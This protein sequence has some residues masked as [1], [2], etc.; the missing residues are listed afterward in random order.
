MK[1]EEKNQMTRQRIMESA[2]KEFSDHG[3]TG[4][5][6]NTI[7]KEEGISKGIIYHYFRTKDE[8][9]LACVEECFGKLTIYL[10]DHLDLENKNLEEQLK[11]YF[12][13]RLRFFHLHPLY[14]RIFCDAVIMP[15]EHLKDDIC[16]LKHDF[17]EFNKEIL[18]RLL[19]V[20]DIRTDL[21]KEEIIEVIRLYQDYINAKYQM[22]GTKEIDL[23]A[24]EE[25]CYKALTILLYGIMRRE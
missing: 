19:L 25:S 8:I 24:H 5:S 18:K 12:A 23:K 13:A 20:A 22:I 2:L 15:A 1:R 16:H 7:C 3:Y 10:K 17:D 9:Y 11:S 4:S 14:Q 21:T 6:V